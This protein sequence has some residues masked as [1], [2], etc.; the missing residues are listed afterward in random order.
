MEVLSLS[1]SA[2]NLKT[3]FRTGKYHLP[4]LSVSRSCAMVTFSI[5]GSTKKS[6]F[7]GPVVIA[8]ARLINQSYVRMLSL[9]NV[10]SPIGRDCD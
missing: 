1:C 5:C 7:P 9:G 4:V 2:W 10:H 8:S 6:L 3:G